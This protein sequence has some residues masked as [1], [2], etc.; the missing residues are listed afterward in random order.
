MTKPSS[1]LG[2]PEVVLPSATSG[3]ATFPYGWTPDG[4][5]IIY[6]KRGV[7]TRFDLYAVALD[8]KKEILLL[9]SPFEERSPAISPD[10]KWLAYYADDTGG[11]EVYVQ[12]FSPD[13]KLGSDRKRISTTGGRMPVWSRDG[14]E[15]F[16]I[17]TD[18][19]LMSSSIKTSGGTLEFSTPKALF[20]TR[21]LADMGSTHEFDIS[22]DGKR[23]L[24]GTLV[25]DSK[26]PLP[27]VILNWPALLKK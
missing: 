6:V 13:A 1:G 11:L 20:K 22:P 26:A 5:Y 2:E 12:S 7:K 3:G 17:A 21:M 8:E 24:I 25:G 14:S 9:N 27:T 19:Q 18:G 16:F 23:F 15:L 4:R 10:G